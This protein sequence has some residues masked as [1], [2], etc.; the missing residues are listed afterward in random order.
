[1][2]WLSHAE[3]IMMI[4]L[5]RFDIIRSVKEERNGKGERET[6]GGEGRGGEGKEWQGEGKRGGGCKG[7]EGEWITSEA[8]PYCQAICI[9]P[10]AILTK[11]CVVEGFL[12]QFS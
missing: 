8:I 3:E 12:G 5:S 1:M 6:I 2:T 11:F 9:I 4:M 7:K 10:C